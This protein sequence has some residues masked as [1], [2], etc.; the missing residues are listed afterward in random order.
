[1]PTSSTLRSGGSSPAFPEG[2]TPRDLDALKDLIF[3][4]SDNVAALQ[5]RVQGGTPATPATSTLDNRMLRVEQEIAQLRLQIQ[6]QQDVTALAKRVQAT[7]ILSLTALL[8]AI[9]AVALATI[10]L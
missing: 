8:V 4:L 1:M 7:F 9:I 6:P 10:G 5:A 2:V 3:Q